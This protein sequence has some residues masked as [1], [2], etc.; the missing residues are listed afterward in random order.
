MA[1]ELGFGLITGV[2]LGFEISSD[3]G[4]TAYIFDLLIL[5]IVLIT[6]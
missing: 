3:E 5:R 6:H 1:F 4:K 2:C